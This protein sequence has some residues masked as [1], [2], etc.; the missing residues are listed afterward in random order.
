MTVNATP[1]GYYEHVN[2]DMECFQEYGLDVAYEDYLSMS[3][4]ERQTLL[5]RFVR[6]RIEI[7]GWTEADFDT[8][9][10]EKF[11]P[12]V[13]DYEDVAG[14]M[15]L[16]FEKRKE[17]GQITSLESVKIDRILAEIAE[18]DEAIDV[19]DLTDDIEDVFKKVTS[20]KIEL[21]GTHTFNE[22]ELDPE[23]GTT[24]VVNVAANTGESNMSGRSPL[25]P[26]NGEEGNP[27]YYDRDHDG[28][29]DIDNPEAEVRF[30]ASG[31]VTTNANGDGVISERDNP[32]FVETPDQ[33]LNLNLA[34]GTTCL[35]DEANPDTLRFLTAE[36]GTYSIQIPGLEQL[37]HFKIVFSGASR[38]GFTE[39][40]IRALPPKIASMIYENAKTK[41][42]LWD[43]VDGSPLPGEA[44]IDYY[45]VYNTSDYFVAANAAAVPP[46]TAHNQLPP[47]IPSAAD[48][49][50]GREYTINCDAGVVDILEMTF[51][52]DAQ[53]RF[54][55]RG[56]DLIM[57]VTN[58]KGESV[59][60]IK[61]AFAVLNAMP[62]VKELDTLKITGGQIDLDANFD[63]LQNFRVPIEYSGGMATEIA[64]R[65]GLFDMITHGG[66]TLHDLAVAAGKTVTIENVGAGTAG[67]LPAGVMAV[68]E[69]MLPVLVA[70]SG[71]MGG[72]L[73]LFGAV[74]PSVFT[75]STGDGLEGAGGALTGGETDGDTAIPTAPAVGTPTAP[76]DA[77]PPATVAPTATPTATIPTTMM[78]TLLPII[79]AESGVM[80]GVL[81]LLDLVA[82]VLVGS[83]AEL[84]GVG[85]ETGPSPV[86]TPTAPAGAT[87]PATVSS[88]TSTGAAPAG[89]ATPTAGKTPSVA[90]PTVPVAGSSA[91][92]AGGTTPSKPLTG[93]TP[94]VV[95]VAAPTSS[96]STV[97]SGGTTGTSIGTTAIKAGASVNIKKS[98]FQNEAAYTINFKGT[99]DITQNING[100]PKDAVINFDLDKKGNLVILETSK[101][102]TVRI[103]CEGLDLSLSHRININGGQLPKAEAL[104]AR[105]A[106]ILKKWDASEVA[107]L[108]A[109]Y[110]KGAD[111]KY[112]NVRKACSN[113][114][115]PVGTGM[116]LGY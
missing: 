50:N 35:V 71:I 27:L 80:N 97:S 92:P 55:S 54:S 47:I 10:K 1:T 22:A 81:S 77:A 82:P 65:G 85:S 89:A 4:D 95:A 87:P 6:D 76:A 56:R 53:I 12:E 40:S 70:N 104:K 79:L 110:V 49:K 7:D 74:D 42:S 17:K 34:E 115:F 109:I 114:L 72:L 103:T 69:T 37:S 31:R 46:V 52:T 112:I 15:A 106:T 30:D 66:T 105:F 58:N 24:Y 86:G 78:E 101:G 75:S 51:P 33:V 111:G 102:K 36:G 43:L 9:I 107:L 2:G 84:A 39:E 99:K 98:D 108:N 90:T 68:M 5:M 64:I 11:E 14:A 60:V 38:G 13:E 48:F 26:A 93:A 29:G 32:N 94:P 73:A 25:D 96:V 88:T 19:D 28:Y 8:F 63:A 61:K 59:Q 3:A 20:E 45:S 57:T 44:E 100:I 116:R 23:N 21:K 67:I 41:M 16:E 113:A 62:G 18:L 91:T 83:G